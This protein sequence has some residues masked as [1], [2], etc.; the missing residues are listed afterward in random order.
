MPGAALFLLPGKGNYAL[1]IHG[2]FEE[3]KVGLIIHAIVLPR[4]RDY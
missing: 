2:H 4:N 1:W 3:E